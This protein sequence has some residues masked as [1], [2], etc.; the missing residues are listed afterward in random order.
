MNIFITENSIKIQNYSF[1]EIGAH[2]IEKHLTSMGAWRHFCNFHFQAH[3]A[4]ERNLKQFL[5]SEILY[6][7]QLFKET[8]FHT[9]IYRLWKSTLQHVFYNTCYT[10]YGCKGACIQLPLGYNI[11]WVLHFHFMWNMF[12]LNCGF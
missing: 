6:I 10:I 4:R 2:A 5:S 12:S 8:K 3:G 1:R 7:Y 11:T 9:K